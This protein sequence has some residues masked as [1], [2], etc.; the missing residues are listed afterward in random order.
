[1]KDPAMMWLPNESDGEGPNESVSDDD[2]GPNQ[3]DSNK[4]LEW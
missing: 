3:S 2:E 1:M 4:K